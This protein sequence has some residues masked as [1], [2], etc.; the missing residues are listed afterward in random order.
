MKLKC[1]KKVIFT[2]PLQ[3]SGCTNIRTEFQ[4]QADQQVVANYHCIFCLLYSNSIHQ[5]SSN[6]A[7]ETETQTEKKAKV[8]NI[9]WNW[10]EALHRMLNNA[11]SADKL[12]TLKQI[13]CW[14]PLTRSQMVWII[15]TVCVCLFVV[16][17]LWKISHFF[18]DTLCTLSHLVLVFNCL[19]LNKSNTNNE[20]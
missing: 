11:A 13:R 8:A 18:R 3:P 17:S 5:F 15:M 14:M 16:P 2:I 12:K 20:F 10:P 7:S 9:Q 4:P 1:S 6:K 19:I